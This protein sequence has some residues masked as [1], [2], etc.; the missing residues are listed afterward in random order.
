M[1]I[2]LLLLLCML[3]MSLGGCDT[4]QV[5]YRRRSVLE[6]HYGKQ[7]GDTRVLSDGTEIRY[8]DSPTKPQ[9]LA[10]GAQVIGAQRTQIR[11]ESEDGTVTLN[12]V[13]PMHVVSNLHE[14]LRRSEY[15]LIYEQIISGDQRGWY[16]SHGDEG[17]EQFLRWFQVNREE[18]AKMLNRMKAGE[19]FGDTNVEI[20]RGWGRVTLRRH[21]AGDFKYSTIELVQ[22]GD[23]LRLQD[24]R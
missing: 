16:Q 22:D 17:Y 23:Q 7:V 15:R 9:Q 4:K 12:Q 24:I 13:L 18:L 11:K 5:E 3:L 10:A 8:I 20:G 19:V 6:R 2:R 14:C 21:V 1:L